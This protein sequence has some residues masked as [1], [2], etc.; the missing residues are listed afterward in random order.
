MFRLQ[1]NR[2]RIVK[3]GYARVST[4]ERWRRPLPW[5]L[6]GYEAQKQQLTAMGCE[7]L[8]CEQLS[9]IASDRPQLEAMHRSNVGRVLAM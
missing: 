3:V 8:C 4:R 6:A 7:K 9:S 1:R 5:Q 2:K